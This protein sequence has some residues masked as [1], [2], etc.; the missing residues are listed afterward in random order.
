MAQNFS[1]EFK[2]TGLNKVKRKVDLAN[3]SNKPIRSYMRSSAYLIKNK[4]QEVA[5]V[6]TGALKRSIRSTQIKSR[7][8]LPQ[9]IQVRSDSPKSK[10]VHGDPKKNGRLKLSE[11]FTRSKPHFPP[12]RKLRGWAERK[13]GNADLA[14]A[15]ARSI[16][17]KGTPLVPYLL[18]A[19]RDT[20]TERKA[21][22]IDL[23]N[24]IE[25]QFKKIK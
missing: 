3:L 13:L 10:Y 12:V 20:K 15:V 5:P 21:L 25:K 17:E 22:L 9:R 7:G 8:R 1:Q 14:Y 18:I 16:A 2:V 19:E 24:D 6:D 23:S 4:A 11:P